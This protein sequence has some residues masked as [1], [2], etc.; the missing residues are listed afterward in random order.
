LKIRIEAEERTIVAGIRVHYQESELI[1]KKIVVVTNL[2]P[3]TIRGIASEG[4]LLAA[5][6]DQALT[7][8]IP[9]REIPDGAK[10]S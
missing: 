7:L 5:S 3:A 10:V 2:E 9:E 4:M 8:L 1:G 6:K